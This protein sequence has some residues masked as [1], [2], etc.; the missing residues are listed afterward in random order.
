MEKLIRNSILFSKIYLGIKEYN[1]KRK[2]SIKHLSPV[3]HDVEI[4][5]RLLLELEAA[6]NDNNTELLIT[7]IPSPI[8]VDD[9][10][11]LKEKYG[12]YFKDL[13]AVFPDISL[14]E[15]TDFD[16]METGNHFNNTGH[17]KYYS[18]IREQI[19]KRLDD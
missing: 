5:H 18:F 10:E 2:W 13:P 19:N 17:K 6:C 7:T 8:D 1:Q 4:T 14:F 3:Q 12:K 11:N 16:G 9:Q 15:T